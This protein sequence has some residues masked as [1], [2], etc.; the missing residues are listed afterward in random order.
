MKYIALILALV[1]M[2]TV[3]GCAG[4][5]TPDTSASS[6]TPETSGTQS[7]APSSSSTEP[8]DNTAG[9]ADTEAAAILRKIW[10]AVDEKDRFAAYGGTVE[11]SVE[12]APGDLDMTNTE[13]LTAKYMIPEDQLPYLQQGASLV[14]MMNSNIFTGCAFKLAQGADGKTVAKAIR[15]H[16]QKVN[17]I[18][19]QPD[20][21]MI[22]L[23]QDHLLMAFGKQMLMQGIQSKL[24]E[25]YPDAQMLY[26]EAVTE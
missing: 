24:T 20:R 16:L 14:H 12:N 3:T 9:T 2:L 22:A 19:G 10:D 8:A 15:D 23:V 21:L 26:N 13:E 7:T 17:W 11:H 5:G 1:M 4:N 25:V 6:S 18:C